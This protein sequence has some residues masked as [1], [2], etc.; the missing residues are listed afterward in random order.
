MTGSGNI[1]RKRKASST[2][3]VKNNSST[4]VLAVA[5][6]CGCITAEIKY[7]S[8]KCAYADAEQSLIERVCGTVNNLTLIVSDA[9]VLTA[10]QHTLGRLMSYYNTWMWKMAKYRVLE[11][12]TN[13]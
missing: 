3:V 6:Y 8:V 11:D 4:R 12:I 7:W 5:L 2:Q 1:N 13:K 10:R 9:N